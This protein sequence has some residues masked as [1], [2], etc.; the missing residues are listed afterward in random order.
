MELARKPEVQ[1]EVLHQV[2]VDSDIGLAHLSL[3][4]FEPDLLVLLQNHHAL[5]KHH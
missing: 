3:P 5:K 1:L 4:H 2:V